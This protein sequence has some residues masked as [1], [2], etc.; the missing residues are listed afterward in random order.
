MLVARRPVMVTQLLIFIFFLA[1][2]QVERSRGDDNE[3]VVANWDTTISAP[4]LSSVPVD[5]QHQAGVH[6]VTDGRPFPSPSNALQEMVEKA[7]AFARRYLKPTEITELQHLV[8]EKRKN[9]APRTEIRAAILAFLN[10]VLSPTVKKEINRHRVELN[11]DFADE[12][13][14]FDKGF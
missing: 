13:I 1:C 11:R 10:S 14:L 7:K 8:A 3:S 9:K 6:N 5:S 12:V 2:L 4:L